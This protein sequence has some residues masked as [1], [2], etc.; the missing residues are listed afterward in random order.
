MQFRLFSFHGGYL[1]TAPVVASTL[2]RS[3]IFGKNS[4]IL[5]SDI[6]K[7]EVFDR[8]EKSTHLKRVVVREIEKSTIL[9][10]VVV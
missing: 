5:R 9:K 3:S 10:R 6:L 1:V 4:T 2:L 8:I 7:R